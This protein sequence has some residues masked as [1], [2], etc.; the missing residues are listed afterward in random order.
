MHPVPFVSSLSGPFIRDSLVFSYTG[1]LFDPGT[2]AT[3]TT[4][5]TAWDM[6]RN[7]SSSASPSTPSIAVTSPLRR[8]PGSSSDSLS[9]ATNPFHSAAAPFRP[10]SS[11]TAAANDHQSSSSSNYHNHNYDPLVL[12]TAAGSAIIQ[13]SPK[14]LGSPQRS[15][16]TFHSETNQKHSTFAYVSEDS[17][18][19]PSSPA[20]FATA[21]SSLQSS[22]SHYSPVVAAAA[23]PTSSS[24]SS[25]S[26]SASTNSQQF[27]GR[28]TDRTASTNGYPKSLVHSPL[29]IASLLKN[30]VQAEA[31]QTIA[32]AQQ[33]DT[34]SS[35]DNHTRSSAN[36]YSSSA[37]THATVTPIQQPVK[38]TGPSAYG[39]ITAA[40]APSTAFSFTTATRETLPFATTS[41]TSQ[42]LPHDMISSNPSTTSTSLLH[43][44]HSSDNTMKSSFKNDASA[45]A[46][47]ASSSKRKMDSLSTSATSSKRAAEKK[48]D[49]TTT[50]TSN[51]PANNVTNNSTNNAVSLLDVPWDDKDGHY[52]I[53]LNSDLSP[54]CR[55]FY[56][57]S[58]DSSLLDKILRM[59]GQGTFGKVVECWDRTTCTRVAV[60]IIRAIPKYRDAAKL[61]I[62]VLNTLKEHDTKNTK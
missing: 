25:S 50:T 30:L 13:D 39:S 9:L 33:Q 23:V 45:T 32:T 21:R 46:G 14:S 56:R 60:K 20:S 57:I 37:R 38:K 19:I 18:S 27:P 7:T 22:S 48:T 4:A 5:T 40:A 34:N 2:S 3:P 17:S 26:S 16:I 35:S 53:E 29:P 31:R 43:L 11:L 55:F 42:L 59:L 51:N 58:S 52:T 41:S 12:P 6:T 1:M 28:S 24:S 10:S 49:T 47:S 61:E 62:R 15:I 36:D 44:P 8:P 54:R